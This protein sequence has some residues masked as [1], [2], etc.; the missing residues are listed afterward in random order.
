MPCR[1]LELQSGNIDYWV[2]YWILLNFTAFS[3]WGKIPTLSLG[4]R[5]IFLWSGIMTKTFGVTDY[6]YI[7]RVC[8]F[9]LHVWRQVWYLLTRVVSVTDTNHTV[10]WFVWV[11]EATKH[12]CSIWETGHWSL[13]MIQ[14]CLWITTWKLQSS[15]RC[16]WVW[17]ENY[18]IK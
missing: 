16:L 17:R 9:E 5:V 12:V 1:W 15:N 6:N 10:I 14:I 2:Q 11:A 4:G 8:C 18:V 7:R 13:G 3:S